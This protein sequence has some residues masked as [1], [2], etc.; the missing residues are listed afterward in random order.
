MLCYNHLRM[1]GH[2]SMLF[3]TQK[4]RLPGSIAE[5]AREKCAPG[6]FGRGKYRCPDGG[7]YELASDGVTAVCSHHGNAMSLAPCREV[8]A[9]S[10]TPA[11]AE[12]YRQFV[13]QY[14]RY[15]RRFFDPI[16]ICLQV[17]PEQYRAETIILPL[18]D[19]S[20]YSGMA[21]AL[22]GEPEPLDA[23]P[24]P[25]RNIF[26]MVTRIQKPPRSEIEEISKPNVFFLR[27]RGAKISEQDAELLKRCL[28]DGIGN[29]I[30]F[31]VYDES[32][33]FDFNLTMAMGEVV[34]SFRGGRGGF[35]D[36]MFW[37]SY[38]IASLNAPVYL[39]VPVQ[40]AE[41]VDRVL[42]R[43]DLFAAEI[44]R[45]G[46]EQG[47][48]DLQLDFYK[49]PLGSTKQQ[50]RCYTIAFGPVKWRLFYARVGDA[51]YVASKRF[52]LEDLQAVADSAID[53]Q[54]GDVGPEAHAMIRIRP[55]NW[56]E[57]LPMFRLGWAEASREACLNNLGP[58][59]AVAKAVASTDG[60]TSAKAVVARADAAHAVHF[61]CPDGGKYRLTPDGRHVTCSKHGT[62]ISPRQGVAPADNS[63]MGKLLDEFGG[64][65]MAL[66]FLEDG[67]HAVVTVERE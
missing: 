25:K 10:V 41:L 57:I 13:A 55:E 59:S 54:P 61:F 6:K 38:L 56:N 16:A 46:D 21:E 18:I 65:T 34:R 51:F 15:W 7:R 37:I 60:K 39:S 48:F 4:G 40:D 2:G 23:L 32:P 27:N 17:T 8:A 44:A 28:Y 49:V 64:V 33:T 31:H 52:I 66:T 45:S 14:S 26:S 24:V 1:I 63:P 9:Y 43:L 58:L 67:L 53:A 20:L 47:W 42:E 30:G 22:G 12:Q 29:Q 62:A 19:N 3:Q 35:D 5:L 50:V 36:D 11:E